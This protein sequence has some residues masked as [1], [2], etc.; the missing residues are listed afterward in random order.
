MKTRIAW[1]APLALIATLAALTA[2]RVLLPSD[3][4]VSAPIG[5]VA[6]VGT[7]PQGI[8]LSPDGTKLAV[9]EA[10]VNPAA[11]RILDARDLSTIR[12]LKFGDAFGAPVWQSNDRILVPGASTDTVYSI[13]GGDVSKAWHAVGSPS[14]VAVLGQR[15]ASANDLN[16]T[17]TLVVGRSRPRTLAVGAHPGAL[18]F[19]HTGKLYVANRAQASLTVF[20]AANESHTISV[21][22][23]PTALAFSPDEST[24]YVACVDSDTVDALNTKDDRVVARIPVGID[25][26]RGASPNGLAVASDGTVYV[27]LGAENA[28]AKIRGGKVVARAPAGWYPTGVA[29]DART[30]YVV[31]GKGEHSRANPQ[32]NPLLPNSE[33]Y[34]GNTLVGSV[35]AIPRAVF[36]ADS[37][38]DVMANVPAPVATPAQTVVRSD[39]PIKHVIYIIKENRTYDQVLGDIPGANGDP[40]LTYYGAR[41]TPNL[42]A[43]AR[44]FGIFDNTYTDSQ[45]SA[46]GHN[47]TDAAFANDY[48]ER[49]WPPSYGGRRDLYDFEDGATGAVPGTGYLWDNAGKH[50]V[51]FR[52]YGEHETDDANVPGRETTTTPGLKGHIDPRYR[53]WDL[54][55]SDDW[56]VNEWKR[57]FGGYVANGDLPSLEIIWLPNDHTYGTKVREWTPRAMVAQ[58]D[59]AFGRIVDIVSHSPYWKNT[60]IFSIEDDAQD[61]PDHVDD[62]RTTFYLISPYAVGGVQHAHYSTSSVVH[63]I[64]LLLGLPPMNVYDAVA[65]PLYDAFASTPV[66][67]SPFAFIPPTIDLNAR[68]TNQ[69]YHAALSEHLDFTHEDAVDPKI[70]N[71]ILA[72]TADKTAL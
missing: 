50:G 67:I 34:V 25:R 12:T 48:V 63:T 61:G 17:V 19:A 3:W 13:T 46:S 21:D 33:G 20:N 6:V 40:K 47:W 71:D 8:A 55:Y 23:H 10:G 11:V 39:G 49:F 59:Y 29:V 1:I 62:Q 65:P 60:A 69:S 43:I 58:N 38:A 56:R 57:E 31:N 15:Y 16:A 28:I 27:S 30:L 54:A 53:S 68:N 18:L 36:T 66:N 45:V 32:F 42:H 41:V 14:A 37:T 26:G 7:M 44:R 9:I 72:H 70:L 22:L 52:D 4:S 51:S 64:E 5:S 2:H 35:R 24:L